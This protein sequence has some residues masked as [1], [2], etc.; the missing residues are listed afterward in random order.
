MIYDLWKDQPD[1]DEE[2]EDNNK[3]KAGNNNS[4]FNAKQK[5]S[6]DVF[7]E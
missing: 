4:Y 2:V 3:K 5:G 1:V 7:E 6:E